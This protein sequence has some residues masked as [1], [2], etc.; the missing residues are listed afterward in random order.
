MNEISLTPNEYKNFFI[1]FYNYWEASYKKGKSISINLFEQIAGMIQSVPPY[2]CGMR[3]Q[4]TIQ[5]VIEA[6]GDIYPCDFY[7]LDEYC[8]GNIKEYSFLEIYHST[9]ARTFLDQSTC[10]K[11]PCESCKYKRIYNGGCRRQ[12]ICYLE[13][14]TCA[15]QEVLDTIIP[16]IQKMMR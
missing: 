7:C 6:N 16:R 15:Y 11:K 4:C 1:E 3:G 9:P 8:L 14:E 2:Q 13:D 12:N 5:Y 10:T